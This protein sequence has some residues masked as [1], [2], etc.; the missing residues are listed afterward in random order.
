MT[1]GASPSAFEIERIDFRRMRAERHRKLIESME[2]SDIDLLLLTSDHNVYYATGART[3]VTDLSRAA[4]H[5]IAAAVPRD[6][7]TPHLFTP[8]PDGVPPDFPEENTHGP[9]SIGSEEGVRRMGSVL[10]AVLGRRLNGKVGTEDST[11][12]MHVL[13]PEVLPQATLVDAGPCVAAARL[14]KTRDEIECI[15]TAE[16]INDL[17]M[18]DVMS[19]LRPGMRQTDLSA[20]LL[21]RV[22]ELGATGNHVDPIWTV[23]PKWLKDGPL[24]FLNDLAF[25][26]YA[27]DRIMRDGD[28]LLV[29]TG[30][31]YMGYHSDF[32]RTWITSIGVPSARETTEMYKRWREVYLATLEQCRPGKTGGDLTRAALQAAGSARKPWLNHLWLIHGIGVLPAEMPFIGTDLGPEFDESIQIQEGMVV[33]V[34]P[35]IYEEGVSCYRSEDI[36]VVTE[37][38]PEVI[39]NFPYTP[40]ED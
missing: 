39:T 20:V 9:L 33:L 8:Y 28:L 37:G 12:A 17:A 13:L 31:E 35:V 4:L 25:P 27:T 40:W 10:G 2:K 36:V 30:I 1:A 22:M 5:P 19:A 24:S 16:A 21:K 34:E 15:R 11:G 7:S 18:Y 29:D 23:V 14:L 38:E 3:M 26:L 6:G 32:G